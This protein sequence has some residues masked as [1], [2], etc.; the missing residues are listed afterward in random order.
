MYGLSI[1]TKIFITSITS[2]VPFFIYLGVVVGYLH[3]CEDF[4]W[5]LQKGKLMIFFFFFDGS[6]ILIFF[7][8]KNLV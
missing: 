8:A 2:E 7:L 3:G 1:C 4:L 5:T 6:N